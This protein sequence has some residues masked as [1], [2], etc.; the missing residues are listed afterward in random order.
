MYS[1]IEYYG[2]QRIFIKQLKT[3]HDTIYPISDFF[4][5][6]VVTDAKVEN[7]KFRCKIMIVWFTTRFY[8]FSINQY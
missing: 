3:I 5:L 6:S 1:S 8:I 2:H 7:K 4:F